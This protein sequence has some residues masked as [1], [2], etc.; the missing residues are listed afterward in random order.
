MIENDS[1]GKTSVMLACQFNC[2][3]IFRILSSLAINNPLSAEKSNLVISK[4]IITL[5]T[6]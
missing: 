2:G 1:K 6:T 5:S 3:W 4:L